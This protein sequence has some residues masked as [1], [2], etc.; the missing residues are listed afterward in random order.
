MSKSLKMILI[1][2]ILLFSGIIFNSSVKA[3]SENDVSFKNELQKDMMYI[4]EEGKISLKGSEFL[5]LLSNT[6]KLDNLLQADNYIYD[7]V[8]FKL[9]EKASNV[10]VIY[11]NGTTKELEIIEIEGNKY[12]KCPVAI[13]EKIS[14]LYYPTCLNIEG[15][16]G[17]EGT[18]KVKNVDNTTDEI[19]WIIEVWGGDESYFG[20]IT[21]LDS[22]IDG[23]NEYYGGEGERLEEHLY[24]QRSM[25]NGDCYITTNLQTYA[26]ETL[27]V[28][29]FGTLYYVGKN[30]DYGFENYT[31]KAVVINKEILNDRIIA[32]IINPEYNV[33]NFC[34]IIPSGDIVKIDNTDVK[35]EDKDTNIKLSGTNVELPKNTELI[36]NEI[37]DG[38]IYD[39]VKNTLKNIANTKNVYDIHLVSDNVKFQPNG[40]IKISIPISNDIDTSKLVIYRISD[41]NKKFEYSFKIETINNIKYATI[42]TNHFSTYVVGEKIE[43]NVSDDNDDEEENENNN[44]DNDSNQS[45]GDG[46][47]QQEEQDMLDDEPKTGYDNISILSIL[48][49][50]V[51]TLGLGI[52]YKI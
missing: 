11:D 42:E 51:I 24:I 49:Y 50:I 28:E 15:L 20:A 52:K 34:V 16:S 38:A 14:G 35:V 4:S 18:L 31:Y 30:N 46:S 22:I 8:Y 32:R 29:P 23:K 36:V 5:K 40:N 3:F 1:I 39:N 27:K 37:K 44:D 47:E 33:M 9:D 2:G 17:N 21:N 41:D 26:G 45:I 43:E 48:G 10:S 19:P 7:I 12:A 6:T 25:I 13:I